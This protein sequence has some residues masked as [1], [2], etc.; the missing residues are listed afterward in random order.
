MPAPRPPPPVL[1]VKQ[2]LKGNKELLAKYEQTLL[3][4]CLQSQGGCVE[5][6]M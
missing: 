3:G 1:Q 2:L 5:A 4:Q 6:L